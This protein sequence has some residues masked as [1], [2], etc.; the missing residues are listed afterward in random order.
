MKNKV[1][2]QFLDTLPPDVDIWVSSVDAEG[3][4]ERLPIESVLLVGTLSQFPAPFQS[5]PGARVYLC[6]WQP[7]FLDQ[8]L[9]GD[10]KLNHQIK[11]G[12]PKKI[13]AQQ[14][15]IA[16]ETIQGESL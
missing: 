11:R 16:A 3:V 9:Q 14:K 15:S 8:R 1:L 13:R 10:A 12:R 7:V 2:K 6:T 4:L 5:E